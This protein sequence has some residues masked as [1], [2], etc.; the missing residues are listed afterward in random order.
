MNM[1]RM[2]N[3]LQFKWNGKHK[4]KTKF[5]IL[6]KAIIIS[7]WYL[8]K[9]TLVQFFFSLI[10]LFSVCDRDKRIDLQER[11]KPGSSMQKV[12]IEIFSPT[13]NDKGKYTLEMFDGQETHKRS[14]DLS[15]QGTAAQ[16]MWLEPENQSPQH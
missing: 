2:H 13:E 11:T 4:N 5:K 9:A 3:N 16:N 14:L 10:D 7:Q 6:I 12:W 8:T 15:G 1:T